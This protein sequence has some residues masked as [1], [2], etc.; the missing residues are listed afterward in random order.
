MRNNDNITKEQIRQDMSEALKNN[1][2]EGYVKALDQMMEC[3][4][5]DVRA[6]FEERV[7]GIENETNARVL[8]ARGVR[9]LT[10]NERE[11]FQ[12]VS[13]AMKAEDPK[14]ALSGLDVVMPE[15]VINSVFDDLTANHPLLS[16]INFVPTKASIKMLVNTSA[17]QLAAWGKLCSEVVQEI[18]AGFKEVNSSLYKLTAFLP[19]CKAMIDLGP[20]WLDRFVR[21][22]LYEAL[23]CGLEHAIINGTGKD[24][25][26]GMN[27]QV[28]EGVS[29]TGGEYPKKAAVTVNE[30]TPETVGALLGE[31]AVDP[32]GKQRVIR[33][34]ILVV[35]AADYYSKVMPATTLMAPDGTYRNDVLPYPMTVIPSAEMDAG[36]AIIGL[37]ERYFADAGMSIGGKI[38]ASD[39]YH[40][41]EDERVYLIKLYANGFPLDNNAFKLLNISGLKPKVLTVKTVTEA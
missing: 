33:N 5:E 28:G 19:V 20:E 21:E 11:Y 26:I 2:S 39:E 37:G 35:S 4:S 27:R 40:F 30:F 1:D 29:V 31:M 3:V 36:E 22:L 7:N 14:Q 23:A 15:T 34:V 13:A 10:K 41:V 32:N 17:H 8:A 12:K 25:P 38:E 16:K 6:E 9:Q 18:A 24:M